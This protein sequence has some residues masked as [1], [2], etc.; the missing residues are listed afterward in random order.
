[1]SQGINFDH[2]SGEINIVNE[3]TIPRATILGRLIEII[4]SGEHDAINLE[5][6]PAEI[7]N[8]IKFNDLNFYRWVVEEYIFNSLLVGNHPI[9]K[10]ISK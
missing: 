2:N 9:L 8:K 6:I 4:A 10:S 3:A 1:M 7:E 5:R